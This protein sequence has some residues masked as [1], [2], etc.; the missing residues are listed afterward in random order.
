MAGVCRA[1]AEPK[2]EAYANGLGHGD[3]SMAN[4]KDCSGRGGEEKV[5]VEDGEERTESERLRLWSIL[6][7]G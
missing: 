4:W 5:D 6:K 1:T 2:W 7:S 3:A